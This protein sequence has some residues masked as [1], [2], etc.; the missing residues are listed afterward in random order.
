MKLTWNLKTWNGASS[1][2]G[3][4]GVCVLGHHATS[5]HFADD[6]SRRGQRQDDGDA[7]DRRRWQD[8]DLAIRRPAS[9]SAGVIVLRSQR[10]SKASSSGRPEPA[11]LPVGGEQRLEMTP[12]PRPQCGTVG[13]EQLGFTGRPR[14]AHE[15]G[16][17][18]RHATGAPRRGGRRRDVGLQRPSVGLKRDQADPFGNGCPGMVGAEAPGRHRLGVDDCGQQGAGHRSKCA[19]GQCPG[20]DHPGEQAIRRLEQLRKVGGGPCREPR[21][22]ELDEGAAGA[23][24]V[25]PSARSTFCCWR[26][27]SGSRCAAALAISGRAPIS[28]T[29]SDGGQERARRRQRAGPVDAVRPHPNA[30]HAGGE[31]RGRR[32]GPLPSGCTRRSPR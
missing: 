6:L 25:T 27:A 13:P 32:A 21:V 19:A 7:L 18:A 23:I 31:G 17:H 29:S 20:G 22:G 24:G 16:Q 14:R 26:Y 2:S 15:A 4:S 11:F 30:A 28:T 9:R 5:L 10:T 1:F 3:S 12:D 8:G